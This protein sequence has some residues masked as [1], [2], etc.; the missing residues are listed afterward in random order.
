MKK[1]VEIMRSSKSWRGYMALGAAA[2]VIVRV[3]AAVLVLA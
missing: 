2:A 1:A 3:A